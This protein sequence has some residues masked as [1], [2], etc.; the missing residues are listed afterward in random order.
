MRRLTFLLALAAGV[1]RVSVSFTPWVQLH[2]V[3]VN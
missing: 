1:V 2:L 3:L